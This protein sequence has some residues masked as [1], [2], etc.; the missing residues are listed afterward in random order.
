MYW[1]NSLVATCLVESRLR[2]RSHLLSSHHFNLYLKIADMIFK[3]LSTDVVGQGLYFAQD[4]KLGHYLKVPPRTLFFAQ[5]SATISAL[6]R[7]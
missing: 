3:I 5:G 6:S 1:R 2:V 4:M 7:A